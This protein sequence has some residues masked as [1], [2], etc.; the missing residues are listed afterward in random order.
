M[1]GI[2]DLVHNYFPE[3]ASIGCF[4]SVTDVVRRKTDEKLRELAVA[5]YDGLT[6]GIETGD[7]N[8]LSFMNKG[9]EAE[10]IVRQCARLDEAGITY[11][12]FYLVGI[13]GKECRKETGDFQ[14]K[15]A[16]PNTFCKRLRLCTGAGASWHISYHVPTTHFLTCSQ[17]IA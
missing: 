14:R 1:L 7:D 12:F 6:I 4:A 8:A 9:Y 15:R 13:S 11:T 5:G 10:D 17:L 2:A 3:C 16:I